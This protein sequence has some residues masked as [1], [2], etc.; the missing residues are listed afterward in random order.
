MDK[1]FLN[2]LSSIAGSLG[3]NLSKVAKAVPGSG[4]KTKSFTFQAVPQSLEQLQAL[5]EAALT[6]VYATAALVILALARWESDRSSAIRMLNFLKGPDDLSNLE[7]QNISDR[8]TDGKAYKLRAFFEG[9][10]PANG[11]TPA[12]PYQ[13]KVS[14][15]P[16]SFPEDNWATLYV[17][18]AGSD[19]PRPMRL[20]KKPSTGQWFLVEIMHLG[21]IRIP[22]AEDKWR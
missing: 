12:Q 1:S 6:D 19:N 15:N 7:L 13:V 14:S 17:Q 2:K 18:S 22:A 4:N 3:L 9:A 11:Y 20:R 10:T 5:P 21:D 16:Y 8:L